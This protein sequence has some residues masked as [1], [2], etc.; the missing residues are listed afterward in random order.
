LQDGGFGC[1]LRCGSQTRVADGQHRVG[2]VGRLLELEGEFGVGQHR[3]DLFHALQRLD[4]AL[5]LLGLAGLGLEAVDELLQ[6]GDLVLLLG[7]AACCSSSCWARRSSKA[8]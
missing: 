4:A 3:R 2:Q 7:K 1:R 8:L 6:V 5:R